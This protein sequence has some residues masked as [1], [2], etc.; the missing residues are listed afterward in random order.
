MPEKRDEISGE[1]LIVNE[2][3]GSNRKKLKNEIPIKPRK[4]PKHE[5]KATVMHQFLVDGVIVDVSES[6]LRICGTTRFTPG[7]EVGIHFLIPDHLKK[8]SEQVPIFPICKVVWQENLAEGDCALHT[9]L[10]IEQLS[11]GQK[12]AFFAF[13]Q[14]LPVTEH[15]S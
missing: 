4:K 3:R 12:N 7:M 9:G 6:G 14:S 11:E 2:Q 8:N 13:V 10:K 1:Y 5:I 15:V